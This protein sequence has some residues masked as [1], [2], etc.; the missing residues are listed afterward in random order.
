[1]N[2]DLEVQN[3]T[4]NFR[5]THIGNMAQMVKFRP[6]VWKC[7]CFKV[8]GYLFR[9]FYSKHFMSTQ[10]TSAVEQY[11]R[12]NLCLDIF[13]SNNHWAELIYSRF[14]IYSRLTLWVSLSFKYFTIFENFVI[15][16]ML[17]LSWTLEA[18]FRKRLYLIF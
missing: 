17:D 5:M 15:V 11:Y 13:G 7:S 16:K 12:Q 1:M 4:M 14:T 10:Y 8:T 2:D 18:V 6:C 3:I 9:A